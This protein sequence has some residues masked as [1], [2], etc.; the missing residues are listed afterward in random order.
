MRHGILDHMDDIVMIPLGE[1]LKVYSREDVDAHLL[2]YVCV[3]DSSTE[4]FL[5]KKA[6]EMESRDLSRTYLAISPSSGRIMGYI[7]LGVKCMTVP[8]ENL[9]SGKVMRNMNIESR[10]GV[11]QSYLIG[12]LSRSSEAPRGLGKVLLD[13]AFDLLS[14]VKGIVGCRMVRL[15]C[16]DELV[17]YY[18]SR[19]FKMIRENG[20]GTLNQMIAFIPDRQIN[21]PDSE[22]M[23][24]IRECGCG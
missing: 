14:I 13:F 3:R 7:T 20:D 22:H 15:D 17:P 16:Q 11:A 6:V 23:F 21:I 1:Y 18:T 12:Q 2:E 24:L 8:E 19:G 5:R 4:A 10:T 9:L